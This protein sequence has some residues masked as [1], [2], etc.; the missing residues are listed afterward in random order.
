MNA[1]VVPSPPLSRPNSPP[2]QP[3][4][5][6]VYCENLEINPSHNLQDLLASLINSVKI[7]S[8]PTSAK[9]DRL[10]VYNSVNKISLND[11]SSTLRNT[12]ASHM[13]SIFSQQPGKGDIAPPVAL[14]T[15]HELGPEVIK[16]FGS[17]FSGGPISTQAA[18]EDLVMVR[19]RDLL[20]AATQTAEKFSLSKEACTRLIKRSLGDSLRLYAELLTSDSSYDL[21][22]V[23]DDLL[24]HT[25]ANHGSANASAQLKELMAGP[26]RNVSTFLERLLA[27]CFKVNAASTNG[28]ERIAS[29]FLLANTMLKTFLQQRAPAVW[30]RIA[31]EMAVNNAS[32]AHLPLNVAARQTNSLLSSLVRKNRELIEQDK[33]FHHR[34]VHEIQRSGAEDPTSTSAVEDDPPANPPKRAWFSQEKRIRPRNPLARDRQRPMTGSLTQR[35]ILNSNQ[36]GNTN[37][38]SGW[39]N[40]NNRPHWSSDSGCLRCGNKGHWARECRKFPGPRVNQPCSSCQRDTG[41][42]LFHEDCRGAN[43]A[44]RQPLGGVNTILL[45]PRHKLQ[46]AP[47]NSF[48]SQP[49]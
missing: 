38:R 1:E 31:T 44:P 14:G 23:Y 48:L 46:K 11:I 13:K 35:A 4:R 37:T 20:S 40:S 49:L 26:V 19:I 41:K 2:P 16:Y 5:G 9:T 6:T 39:T 22:D 43:T 45:R 7:M 18:D 27:L 17:L 47:K 34:S 8:S 21:A 28:E 3:Q 33:R 25:D 42:R 36:R 32:I 30:S 12:H 15:N 24:S 29:S 10:A